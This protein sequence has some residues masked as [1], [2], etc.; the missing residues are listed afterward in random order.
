MAKS[1][2]KVIPVEDKES[3]KGVDTLNLEAILALLAES[4]LRVYGLRK[5]I[6]GKNKEVKVAKAMAASD[7]DKAMFQ[8]AQNE[9]LTNDILYYQASATL[10]VKKDLEAARQ[11]IL[12]LEK[13][14][15][16]L[17]AEVAPLMEADKE[18]KGLHKRVN[19][20]RGR[21]QNQEND[22]TQ[23]F[24]EKASEEKMTLVQEMMDDCR[25]I[26]K[27]TGRSSSLTGY[28]KWEGQFTACSD[29]FNK[30][31]MEQAGGEEEAEDEAFDSIFGESDQEEDD[32]QEADADE[33]EPPQ[34]EVDAEKEQAP[35]EDP[36]QAA[37]DTKCPACR[38]LNSRFS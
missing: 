35:V 19:K 7:S 24:N 23:N 17:K 15:K 10:Q 16:N 38:C 36:N 30:K 20:H 27:M 26:M 28:E 5:P 22:L 8:I 3:V 37:V 1:M 18:A 4:M 9:I 31:I 11:K 2:L 34:E 32:K 33:E 21:L 29:Q 13:S 6:S 25:A 14:V 12:E